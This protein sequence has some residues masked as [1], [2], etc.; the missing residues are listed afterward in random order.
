MNNTMSTLYGAIDDLFEFN[1]VACYAVL[2]M[3]ST[4]S[5]AHY[6]KGKMALSSKVMLGL[7]KYI[8]HYTD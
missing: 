3:D 5:P 8:V 2:N 4:G 6:S 7:Y 1:I